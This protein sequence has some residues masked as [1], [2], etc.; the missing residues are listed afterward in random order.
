MAASVV[1][2][3][4]TY[5]IDGN[6]TVTST[7]LRTTLKDNQVFIRATKIRG[8]VALLLAYGQPGIF[9]NFEHCKHPII[10]NVY[11]HLL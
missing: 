9:F 1:Y 11:E 4:F 6:F 5:F 2:N 7:I 3:N 10:L 8:L